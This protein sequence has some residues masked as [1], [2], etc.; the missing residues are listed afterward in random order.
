MH[1]R[2]SRILCV[3]KRAAAIFSILM[4]NVKEPYVLNIET[5]KEE[6][7]NCG[8][9]NLV[10]ACLDMSAVL[11]KPFFRLLRTLLTLLDDVVC[12]CPVFYNKMIITLMA[13]VKFL[14]SIA[15]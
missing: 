4:L 3:D 8:R 6:E 12:I 10:S 2:K 7:V 1:F 9:R 14:I 5:R 11:Y 15:I 13:R